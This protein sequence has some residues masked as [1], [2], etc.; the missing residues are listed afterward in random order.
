MATNKNFTKYNYI[1]VVQTLVPELYRQVDYKEYGE[2][3][4][5][6]YAFLGKILRA[7]LEYSNY[8]DV[9]GED[10]KTFARFFSPRYK[11]S[12]CTPKR[13]EKSILRPYGKVLSDFKSEGELTSWVSSVLLPAAPLNNP[14]GF[15][16]ALSAVDSSYSS[17]SKT[18]GYLLDNLGLFYVLNTSSVYPVDGSA[19][20]PSSISSKIYQGATLTGARGVE[21]LF[22]WFW[23]NKADPYISNFFPSNY[24]KLSEAAFDSSATFDKDML[25]LVNVHVN[26]WL[27]KSNKDPGFVDSAIDAVLSTG[28]FPEKLRDAGPFQ[29]FLKAVSLGLADYDNIIEDI[30]QLLDIDTCPDQ[31]LE[32]LGYYIGWEFITGDIFRWRAQLRDAVL[33]YKT[34][35][36]IMGV[37]A[38]LKLIFPT[39]LFSSNDINEC[40]EHYIPKMLYYLLRTDSFLERENFASGTVNFQDTEKLFRQPTRRD[41]PY[42]TLFGLKYNQSQSFNTSISF[43]VDMILEDMHNTFENIRWKGVDFKESNYIQCLG[44]EPFFQHRGAD[45]I[46]PPWEKYGFYKETRFTP[47]IIDHLADVLSG[48]REGFGFEVPQKSVEEFRETARRAMELSAGSLNAVPPY[49][50]N[51]EFRFFTSGHTL[52]PNHDKVV[53]LFNDSDKLHTNLSDYWNTKSSHIF[54]I[55]HA[56]SFDWFAEDYD[57]TK[58]GAALTAYRK[59]LEKFIPLHVTPKII[60]DLFLEDHHCVT[61]TLCSEATAILDEYNTGLLNSRGGRAFLGGS[62]TGAWGSTS[63]N[64][65]GRRLPLAG[66][67]FW[68]ATATNLERNSGRRRG[69]RYAL[70]QYPSTREGKGHPNAL[71]HFKYSN[72]SSVSAL[73][74]TSY[75]NTWEYII[76][77]FDYEYQGYEDMS[78]VTWNNDRKWFYND[79][80]CNFDTSVLSG[81]NVSSLYPVRG[82]PETDFACSSWLRYRDDMS[83]ILKV[84]TKVEIFRHGTSATFA[85]SKFENFE[86]GSTYAKAYAILN[87][88]FNRKYRHYVDGSRPFYGGHN[89]ASYAYGPT[90]FNHDFKYGGGI[91]TFASSFAAAIPLSSTPYG[92]I[93]GNQFSSIVGGNDSAGE[94]YLSHKR[95]KVEL[96]SPYFSSD[97]ATLTTTEDGNRSKITSEI[98]SGIRFEQPYPVSKSFCVISN[99]SCTYGTTQKA[100]IAMYNRDNNPLR[101]IIPFE[102]S[103]LQPLQK[104][105]LPNTTLKLDL[106]VETPT[107]PSTHLLQVKI[108]TGP[109]SSTDYRWGYNFDE[110]IWELYYEDNKFVKDIPITPKIAATETQ[111]LNFHTIQSVTENHSCDTPTPY[112]EWSI[113]T[114]S[115]DYYI[116]LTSKDKSNDALIIHNI[117]VQDTGLRSLIGELDKFELQDVFDYW[118]NLG[119]NNYYS[120]NKTLSQSTF[121][122]EGGSRGVYLETLGG[123]LSGVTSGVTTEF[124][125]ED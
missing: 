45:V 18:H 119:T 36:S 49:G 31:F 110:D 59:A 25:S 69:H 46:I 123:S 57:T 33:A 40:W 99:P 10:N 5:P 77:G 104:G 47:D 89:Y 106:C 115:T 4:D 97:R 44:R 86:W 76:K 3:E 108:I 109:V 22:N 84:M 41:G 62:G 88:T 13:F 71:N 103:A 61:G 70:P 82:I 72:V 67:Q 74:S 12:D 118:K 55:L 101:V 42:P 102:S 105:F 9:S 98:L 34:K 83:D 95:N 16:S 8:L 78:S 114:S 56:S 15:A 113:H 120:R 26:T 75:L 6:S 68:S 54:T 94:I 93:N 60:V 122:A 63:I 66:G 51:N 87:T 19:L 96:Y 11:V 112:A 39:G 117:S 92:K 48:T 23:G 14:V 21:L 64:P 85:D 32:F 29:R 100:S 38:V 111:S 79:G 28:D 43:M 24:V 107:L 20:V 90:M 52:P 35:G 121:E 58:S 27:S 80:S 1:D 124:S 7:A 30:S 2:Y 81:I 50:L 91:D 65:D 125:V 53:D 116:I 17:V 73:S 37:E